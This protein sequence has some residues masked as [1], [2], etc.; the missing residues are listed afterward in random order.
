MIKGA[1]FD[2]D[3]TLLDTMP[4]W[5]NSGANYLAS[6]GIEAEP[7][8]GDKLFAMTVDMGAEYLKANYGLPQSCREIAKGINGIVEG[9][10]FNDADF[11]LGAR[12]LLDRMKSAKIPLAIATST[13]KYCIE[14]AFDRLGYKDYFDVILTCG[15]VGASKSN[16]KIFF[17]AVAALGTP[18]EDTWLFEDGLYSIKT[19]K[20]EGFKIVGV[21]DKVSEADQEGIKQYAD[22]YVKDLIEFT[23]I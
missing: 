15:E 11:K 10:Y 20:A 1:I 7:R 18:I 14:A 3:G 17:E 6:L 12:E 22:I 5:T 2:V 21:Y 13:E 4:I 9:H 8:L 23:L 16:P 19:A